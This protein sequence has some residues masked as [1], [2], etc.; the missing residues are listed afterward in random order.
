MFVRNGTEIEPHSMPWLVRLDSGCTGSII[1]KRH[2]LTAKH[3]R[4][5]R[6]CIKDVR[7]VA[8]GA[9]FTLWFKL[10]GR[11]GNLNSW[12]R[13]YKSKFGRIWKA[14]LW[15][16]PSC[17]SGDLFKLKKL[18]NQIFTDISRYLRCRWTLTRASA[19]ALSASRLCLRILSVRWGVA[20][21]RR[22]PIPPARLAP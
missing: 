1:G 16:H 19:R 13:S 5:C 20:G 17:F 15:Q 18:A 7:Y 12:M 2:V 9:R 4:R 3:C 6:H 14:I 11:T 10:K 22:D 21:G 8:V